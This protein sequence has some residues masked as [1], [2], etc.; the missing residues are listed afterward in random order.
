MGIKV[1]CCSDLHGFLPEI[2]DCDLLVLGGDYCKD[3][4]NH[5]WYRDIFKPWIDENANRMKIVGCSGNHDFMFQD[6]PHLIPKMNWDYL[7]DNG[8]AWNGLNIWGSPWQ[9]RFFDWA[10]N[11]DEPDL[12]KKWAFIP[13]NTDILVLHSPPLGYGDFSSY[14]NE[15]CGSPSL[16]KRIEEIKPRLVVFGHVHDSSGIYK[17]G[18]TIAI[19]ASYVNGKYQPTNNPIIVE[20]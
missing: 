10:F 3:H 18:D 17:I 4:R 14:G 7:Q 6:T 19:N 8:I 13:D 9:K 5:F 16:L 2:P 20:I 15:H 1:C 12:E 11:L